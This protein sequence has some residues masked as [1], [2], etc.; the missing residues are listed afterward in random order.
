MFPPQILHS[1]VQVLL[2]SGGEALEPEERVCRYT[3]GSAT[4]VLQ[5]S[6]QLLPSGSSDTNPIFLFS[7]ASIEAASPPQLVGAGE[8]GPGERDL[9]PEVTSH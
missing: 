3:A 6:T 8:P 7:M 5:C 9:Q 1:T 2:I 4:A